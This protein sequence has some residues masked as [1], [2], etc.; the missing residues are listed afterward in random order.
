[1]CSFAVFDFQL[2]G[3]SNVKSNDHSKSDVNTTTNGPDVQTTSAPA[4]TTGAR[5]RQL[6]QKVG[7]A[8]GQ[9]QR[10]YKMEKS[11]LHFKATHPDWQPDLNGSIFLDKI[12]TYQPKSK[13]ASQAGGRGLGL[14]SSVH[15]ARVGDDRAGSYER[16]WGA[17]PHL[18]P[19]TG[20]RR[21]REMYD[22][23][24]ESRRE[25]EEDEGEGEAGDGWDNRPGDDGDRGS[26]EEGFMRDAGMVGL[27]QQV[28]NR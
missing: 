14:G 12:S 20:P 1:V 17:G 19:R 4:S 26:E 16:T 23:R 15:G 6:N 18:R 11:F 24:L 13:P 2:H 3:N 8:N 21:G 9:G 27:L 22:S 7:R 5:K 28:L 25:D 10:D